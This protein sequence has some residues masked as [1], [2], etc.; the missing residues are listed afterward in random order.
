MNKEFTRGCDKDINREGWGTVMMIFTL[1]L[2]FF[3][4]YVRF[5][6][7]KYYLNR[8]LLL[9]LLRNKEITLKYIGPIGKSWDIDEYQ[10]EY[11][12][13][14]Y[15]IWHFYKKGEF[16]LDLGEYK[17]TL[18]MFFGKEGLS[19]LFIGDFVEYFRVKKILKYFKKTDQTFKID[20]NKL[21]IW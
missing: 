21:K 20:D 5:F 18:K 15:I 9:Y 12:D 1:A 16:T 8:K 14:T 7:R 6:E 11:H 4:F 13:K 10:F 19:G 17:T 2:G 3:F